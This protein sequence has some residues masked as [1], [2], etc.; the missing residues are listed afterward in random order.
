MKENSVKLISYIQF[1]FF[2]QILYLLYIDE[3]IQ[4]VYGEKLKKHYRK[5]KHDTE[6]KSKQAIS[7]TLIT[8]L[9][10]TGTH[11]S[12][13]LFGN[14]TENRHRTADASTGHECF[15]SLN[16]GIKEESNPQSLSFSPVCFCLYVSGDLPI[17]HLINTSLQRIL[18]QT[19]FP[20]WRCHDK[21]K[22]VPSSDS[23]LS[24]S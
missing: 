1:S 16:T 18:C 15:Y 21:Q 2:S 4:Q 9:V 20:H 10:S 11:V 17:S 6:R 12:K 3:K 23:H 22:D 24:F 13:E 19:L 5:R 7:F 14:I 8:N